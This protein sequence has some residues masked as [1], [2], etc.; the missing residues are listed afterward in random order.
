MRLITKNLSL[1]VGLAFFIT[2]GFV[3]YGTII[4]QKTV[5]ITRPTRLVVRLDTAEGM[6]PGAPVLILGV[7]KGLVAALSYLA[8]DAAG[9]PIPWAT[10]ADTGNVQ[11]QAVFAVLD[12][13]D[14]VTVYKNHRI[15]TRYPNVFSDKVVD[16][17]PGHGQP[18][19][20]INFM[21]ISAPEL[22]AFRRGEGLPVVRGT[23]AA[24]SNYDDPQYLIASVLG[25][26]R[27]PLRTIVHNVR[28]I[29]DKVNVGQGTVSAFVNDRSLND[30]S[31]KLFKTLVILTAEIREGLEDTRESRGSI[32]MLS[33]IAT[34][35][36]FF[37]L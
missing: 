3:G 2:M 20:E 28:E 5:A 9:N 12:M 35:V 23:L 10:A 21:E 19:D 17:D 22:L 11:G 36:G 16:I 29:T 32:D 24:V 1:G 31:N 33:A 15:I 13:A 4:L 8:L 34:I 27:A 37:L 7:K 14:R 26:N 18:A 30:E 6:R 25:E